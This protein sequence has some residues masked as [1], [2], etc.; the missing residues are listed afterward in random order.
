MPYPCPSV[1]CRSRRA[2]LWVPLTPRRGGEGKL[3]K[4]TCGMLI[5]LNS[6]FV[7]R[8]SC[9]A[10]SVNFVFSPPQIRVEPAQFVFY[11]YSQTGLS[12]NPNFYSKIEFSR[13]KSEFSFLEKSSWADASR[14]IFPP[15]TR[16]GSPDLCLIFEE[17][18]WA[19][20]TQLFFQKSSWAGSTQII[21]G[22][23]H[24]EFLSHL[25]GGVR[26]NYTK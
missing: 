12:S 14:Q 1:S 3:H 13:F 16:F 4:V 24:C 17:S 19:G 22:E 25:G 26:G 11:V 2:P 10:G 23:H 5:R 18:C 15:N 21:V 6:I 7:Y 9:W 8:K 20:S